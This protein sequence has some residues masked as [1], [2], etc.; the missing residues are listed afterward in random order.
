MN[1]RAVSILFL[2]DAGARGR[3]ELLD[4]VPAVGVV[5]EGH[6]LV[7]RRTAA[8][9]GVPGLGGGQSAAQAQVGEGEFVVRGHTWARAAAVLKQHHFI[10]VVPEAK[11]AHL[12]HKHV[13]SGNCKHLH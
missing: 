3:R 8:W 1:V 7:V 13:D 5:Q 11:V 10:R 2:A 4:L 6:V 12:Q 9:R